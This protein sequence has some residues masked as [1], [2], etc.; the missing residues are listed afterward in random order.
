[1]IAM[2]SQDGGN[3]VTMMTTMMTLM[4]LMTMM[5]AMMMNDR[6]HDGG[7]EDDDAEG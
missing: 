1:M 4:T 3:G 2:S 7:D 5:T 6:D